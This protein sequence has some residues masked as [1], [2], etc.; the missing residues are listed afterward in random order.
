METHRCRRCEEDVQ[1]EHE[2][3]KLR[4][5]ARLY[6]LLPIPF[7]PL[8][9]IIASDFM[10]MIPLMMLYLL[11]AGAAFR[12]SSQKPTCPECGAFVERL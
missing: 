5:L 10:V 6:F 8:L 4:R 11:G 9:P 1:G 12:F 7:V 2:Q 3:P